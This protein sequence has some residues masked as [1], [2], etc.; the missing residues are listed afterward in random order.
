[1]KQS[2]PPASSDS[3]R[4]GA[5]VSPGMA[6]LLKSKPPQTGHPTQAENA[7][8]RALAKISLWTADVLL[9][10]VS[11]YLALGSSAPLSGARLALCVAS[12]LMGAWLSL[13]ALR[14]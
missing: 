5:K 9:L 14:L 8:N 3:H 6:S 12:L 11:A 2:N 10:G 1:M 7:V 4:P 13:L